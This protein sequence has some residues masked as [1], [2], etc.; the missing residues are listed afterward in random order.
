M[1]GTFALVLVFTILKEG[2]EDLQ[3]HKQDRE[4]NSKESLVFDTQALKFINKQWRD[5]KAGELIKVRK[6]EEFPS[7]IVLMKSDNESGIVYVDTMN[8]DGEVSLEIY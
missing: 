3:R 7:D 1:I 8:L 4:L 6:D 5:I 2:F